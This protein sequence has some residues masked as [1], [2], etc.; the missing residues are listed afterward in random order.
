MLMRNLIILGLPF[1]RPY[2]TSATPLTNPFTHN[3]A[4]CL[5]SRQVSQYEVMQQ[6][7]KAQMMHAQPVQHYTGKFAH[8]NLM[9]KGM[10]LP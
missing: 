4:L 6:H 9:A 2:S 3:L 5:Y 7:Y 1:T 10:V 8:R